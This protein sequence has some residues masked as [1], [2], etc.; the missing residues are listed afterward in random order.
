MKSFTLGIP[1]ILR[2]CPF[3]Q[4][5]QIHELPDHHF[6]TLKFLCAHLKRVSDN[7]EKNKVR[8]LTGSVSVKVIK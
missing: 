2:L 3:S 4:F 1:F 5:L 7:C 8:A 6:E